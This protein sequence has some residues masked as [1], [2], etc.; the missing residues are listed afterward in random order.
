MSKRVII[1]PREGNALAMLV[2]AGLIGEAATASLA[3][4]TVHLEEIEVDPG[5]GSWVIR[6][7]ATGAVQ[8]GLE[9]LTARW[10]AALQAAVPGLQR[11]EWVR[12][13]S[14]R[15]A[16]AGLPP[17]RD[18]ASDQE[19][20]A[21]LLTQAAAGGAAAPNGAAVPA[22]GS[23]GETA[24]SP[25]A[26]AG[27]DA[28][29]VVLWGRPIRGG[30][31]TPLSAVS[32]QEG[33]VILVGQAVGVEVR[34]TRQGTR[35][36]QFDL[37]D[38]TDAVTVK[39]F[40]R[41]PRSAGREPAQAG[42]TAADVASGRKEPLDKLLEEAGWVKVRGEAVIDRFLGELVVEARDICR[43]E[44]PAI[45]QDLAPA[46][47]K[48]VELHLHTK[49][50]AMDATT[51]VAAAIRRAAAW[52]QP[53][54]AITDHGVCQS[55]PAAYDEGKKLGI[56]ILYGIEG[57]LVD[58]ATDDAHRYHIIILARNQEGLRALYELVSLSHLRYF[59]RFP[60]LPRAEVEKR[61]EHLILGSACESGELF[62]AVL[63][64][65]PDDELRKIAG[66]YDYLEIQPRSNNAFLLREGQVQTEEQLLDLNR[67]IY[68]LGQELG[69]PVVA[70]GDVH[71]LDPE[72]EIYRQIILAA[73]G[74]ADV[75]RQVPLYFRT[76][77]E[78]LQ[79]FAYLGKQAAQ[80]V[81]VNNPVLVASW[82]QPIMPVPDHLYAPDIPEAADTIQ[83]LAWQRAHELY[84]D[85]LP[86]RVEQRLKR[87]L[88][89]I[90]GN[91]FAALY[92]IA[93]KLVS[94]SLA[95]GYLVGSRGSVGS[96]LVAT[97]C[98]ITEVNPLPPHYLC[99]HCH[100]CE[101]VDDGSVGAG[102]D[103]PQKA[104]PHC[105]TPLSKLGFNIPF[106]VFMGFHGEKVPDI[107]LNFSGEYQPQVHQ[108]T[109]ELFGHDHVFRAGTI[110]TL[111]DKT[112]YGYVRAYAQEK[113]LQ[114][115]RAQINQLVR[116]ITGVKRTTGQHPGGLM[117]V[118]KQL[119]VHQFTPVQH[120]ANDKTSDII[121]THFDY[122]SISERLVKVDILG[123]DD[124]TVLRLLR[125]FTGVDPR[126]VP[127]DDPKVLQLF[128][129]C[130][131]LGVTAEQIG[132]SVGTLGIP[133]FNTRFV[134]T[135]LEETHPRTFSDLVRISGFSHGTNVWANNAQDL[136]REGK[137]TLQ[138]AI[139]CR[140]DIMLS[141]MRWGV[142]PAKAFKIMEQVRKGKGLK[143]ED[144]RLMKEHGVPD[145]YIESCHKI[146]Y[147]FPK[148]HAVAYVTMEVRIAYFKLYYP[149]AFYAA[150]FTV[151]A[152]AFDANLVLKGVEA[153]RAAMAEI[154]AK[155]N[156]ATAREKDLASLL[157]VAIE[158]NQRGIRFLPVD[159]T[160][161]HPTRF[162]V[163]E[164]ALLP[165]L[166]SLP[167]L[168]EQAAR[169]L[170]AA[171]EEAPFTS[172][173]DIRLRAHVSRAVIDVL[174][175]AQAL[176][177]LPEG[178]QLALF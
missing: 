10:S 118:P 79:E 103:L 73:K 158:A 138:E 84:G 144:E 71:F 111:A 83:S 112:A 11:I 105:G 150:H 37:V 102:V 56:K 34:E 74:Y 68:Q 91:G 21:V 67:R 116:G 177:G 175:A 70:T 35:I 141:L 129:S 108:Y 166:V 55:F 96:S 77:D 90:I 154:E 33:P 172:I 49:M 117:I 133:E 26:G 24:G 109:E 123:H 130:E 143:P 142:E 58:A 69:K 131:P 48:R 18:A 45:R 135:M 42:G 3:G 6:Y 81:V 53:A 19:Y 169:A 47:Q 134:R 97:M 46:G 20:M 57:Y 147:M 30:Q 145:W 139:G 9:D 101:F 171:R 125:E 36:I 146:S 29:P 119:D 2:Q 12:G 7:D 104:C 63:S 72:D 174:R 163:E 161:S 16:G 66:F 80:D 159:V 27:D 168:G 107:D 122:H 38:K 115:R 4:G 136:I 31:I 140:D 114:L 88:D 113:G 39:V 61:R 110:A 173:E 85:P 95:D 167:G 89:A 5:V 25:P 75:E 43:A 87:E 170:A 132:T 178:A 54:V 86:D 128:S 28:A 127:L 148:A 93:Q 52:G 60:R 1:R 13:D 126:T 59:Y 41:A 100:F 64:Q 124:P 92:W 65:R 22:S 82:V 50:S 78:M 120:P 98:G 94:K 99:P 160:R 152:E 151:K 121:T 156:E 162:Q 62:Q 44:P 155:G 32:V 149:A 14:C 8:L 106:E 23:A 157:E 51:D 17:S 76:T 40:E 153:M 15:T 164:N 165:P 176:P 137:A